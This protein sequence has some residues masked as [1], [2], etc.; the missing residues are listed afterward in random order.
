MESVRRLERDS[1][2]KLETKLERVL[3]M[4]K[5]TAWEPGW[6]RERYR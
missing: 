6:G 3:Q 4:E 2:R 5:A 1:E